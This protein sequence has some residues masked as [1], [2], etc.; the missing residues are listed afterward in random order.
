MNVQSSAQKKVESRTLSVM[1]SHATPKPEAS[2]F[3]LV[4]AGG[5]L[6]A[7][8]PTD[9]DQIVSPDPI[10]FS[11]IAEM[12]EA[13]NEAISEDDRRAVWQE[14][15]DALA[16]GTG[17]RVEFK[18]FGESDE[19]LAAFRRGELHIVALNS[20]A[21]Q[22][23][24]EGGGFVPLCTLGKA[25]GSYL[26]TMKIIVPAG[27][28]VTSPADLRGHRLTFTRP[29]SNSGFKAALI[30]LMD[31]YDMLPERDYE[32]R[33]SL[34]HD[35]SIQ[36]VATGETDAAPVASDLLA[37]AVATGQV[38]EDAIRTIHESERFPP[39]AIGVPYNLAPELRG[40]IEQVFVHFD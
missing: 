13:A 31:Q 12:P 33:F 11:Y 22:A 25:D 34:G 1:L 3:V 21:V 2:G 18:H 29:I 36:L 7:D 20:G 37:R 4:D 39:A 14:L 8:L 16:D 24:V 5:D 38:K 27:S 17:R 28:R 35:K 15:L 10:V 40:Q 30:L 6:V 32:A 19:Q 9:P 23:A 26:H